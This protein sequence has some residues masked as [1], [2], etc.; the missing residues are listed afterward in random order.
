MEL[1]PQIPWVG[2]SP[3]LWTPGGRRGLGVPKGPTAL[4][5]ALR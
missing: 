4:V 2:V 1:M 5:V 3:R